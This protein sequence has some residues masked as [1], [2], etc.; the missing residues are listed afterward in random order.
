MKKPAAVLLLLTQLIILSACSSGAQPINQADSSI[1]IEDSSVI[2]S[3]QREGSF[4]RH[5]I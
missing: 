5:Q 3:Q 1:S 2:Y 4:R